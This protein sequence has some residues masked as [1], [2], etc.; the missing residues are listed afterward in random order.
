MIS[1]SDCIFYSLLSGLLALID[2]TTFLN[3]LRLIIVH[4][5]VTAL[6]QSH[7]VHP[8]CPHLL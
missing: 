6:E 8:L 4:L 3:R 7:F 1:L 2:E 5:L